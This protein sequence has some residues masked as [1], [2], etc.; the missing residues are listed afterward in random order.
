V[1]IKGKGGKTLEKW[2]APECVQL[3]QDY[4]QWMDDNGRTV[5]PEDWLF[6][7]TRNPLNGNLIK[8]LNPK[9]IDYIFK[10]YCQKAGVL[11]RVS[12]HS[13]RASYIGSAIDGGADLYKIAQD[14]GH[15]SVKTTE[16][17]NKRKRKFADSP[18]HHL[19]FLKEK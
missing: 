16:E 19:G 9:S 6:Q 3:I 11:K 15:S 18:V 13:A 2:V 14:V 7:P 5:H 17:Y 4:L 10:Q 12:V 1:H 8:P